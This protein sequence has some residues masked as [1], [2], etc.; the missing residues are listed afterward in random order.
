MASRAEAMARPWLM[1]AAAEATWTECGIAVAKQL[2]S[3]KLAATVSDPYA[4]IS[5]KVAEIQK[6]LQT[7]DGKVLLKKAGRS[8]VD[9]DNA[10]IWTTNLRER[11]NALH[12]GKAKSFVA[13]HSETASL[14]MG[15]PLHIGTL[16]AIRTVT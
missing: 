6:T 7:P 16:E 4:S 1:A 2:S 5:K 8:S 3:T 15:A 13:D 14:I 11:R 9:V 12:W 10:Q